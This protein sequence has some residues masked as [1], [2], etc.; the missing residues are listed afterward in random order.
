[1]K[2]HWKVTFGLNA[3]ETHKL[4]WGL[5]AS[6]VIGFLALFGA[7]YSQVVYDK[8]LPA[9][10]TAMDSLLAITIAVL[11]TQVIGWLFRVWRTNLQEYANE[12][13]D[14]RVSSALYRHIVGCTMSSMPRSHTAVAVWREGE[15]IREL[16][17]SSVVF[18]IVDIVFAA[19]YVC[20]IW[21]L[22]GALALIPLTAGGILLAS[23]AIIQSLIERE[24]KRY[25]VASVDRQRLLQESVHG[26][27]DLKLA[28]GQSGFTERMTAAIETASAHSAKLRR[29][30]A[31]GSSLAVLASGSTSVLTT[32]VGA[33]AVLEGHITMGVLF[34][35][36]ILSARVIEPFLSVSAILIKIGRARVAKELLAPIVEAQPEARKGQVVLDDCRGEVTFDHVRFR[37]PG[38]DH[39][40]LR[41]LDLH[42]KPGEK[43][44]VLGPRGAGKST[45]WRLA[46]GLYT[47]GDEAGSGAVMIDG[48]NVKSADPDSVR[49]FVGVLPQDPVLFS[50][51]LLENVRMGRPDATDSDV[52]RAC[53]L[54]G[55]AEWIARHPLG[56]GL[57]I[58]EQGRNLSGGERHSIALARLMLSDPRV[59]ILDE[60]TSNMDEAAAGALMQRLLGWLQGRTAIIVTHRQE[61]LAIVDRA[62]RIADGR[63]TE[64]FPGVSFRRADGSVHRAILPEAVVRLLPLKDG[65]TTEPAIQQALASAKQQIQQSQAEK[66]A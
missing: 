64:T 34:V 27:V 60:P 56:Y 33:G 50:G 10:E 35:L 41:G 63:V 53:E 29:L 18:T 8:I 49:R 5:I 32:A 22:A 30:S 37:Y 46:T 65:M 43:V 59:V 45:I 61:P 13:A 40:V 21:W 38:T 36:A 51:N 48:V 14:D 26:V 20:V 11:V 39:E 1:M 16:F 9:G 28:R 42:V 7:L 57:P 24:T 4:V 47:V 3:A 2:A 52:K 54:A 58:V 25:T 23:T 55:A 17:S 6:A 31:H 62:V 12:S 15:A 19:V 44:A 66:A